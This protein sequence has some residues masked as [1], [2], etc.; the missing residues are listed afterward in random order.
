MTLAHLKQIL[1]LMCNQL[2]DI[3]IPYYG[4]KEGN[5]ESFGY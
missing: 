3:R 4:E 2:Y 5:N 1:A